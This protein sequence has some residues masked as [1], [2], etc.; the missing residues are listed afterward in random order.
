MPCI[1]FFLPRNVRI[2]FFFKNYHR[3]DKVQIV[4]HLHTVPSICTEVADN[5]ALASDYAQ[6]FSRFG[7]GAV[8]AEHRLAIRL[9]F[10]RIWHIFCQ[11]HALTVVQQRNGPKNETGQKILAQ[12]EQFWHKFCTILEGMAMEWEVVEQL[13]ECWRKMAGLYNKVTH[14]AWKI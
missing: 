1:I 8:R 2:N 14:K 11:I 6:I 13:Y 12:F 7:L 4:R 9:L 10:G 5:R 3:L